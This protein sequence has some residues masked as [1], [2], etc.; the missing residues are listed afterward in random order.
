MRTLKNNKVINSVLQ[1]HTGSTGGTKFWFQTVKL[2][3]LCSF[4]LCSLA[5][6]PDT[7]RG[8]C[9]QVREVDYLPSRFRNSWTYWSDPWDH[10]CKWLDYENSHNKQTMVKKESPHFS[11]AE[12]S[13]CWGEVGNPCEG[14]P[15][16]SSEW[17]NFH[18]WSPPQLS[19]CP[20]IPFSPGWWLE[21][22]RR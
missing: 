10:K 14:A 1:G 19:S 3:G 17:Q 12:P 5:S 7:G 16:F 2:H 13:S 18:R 9:F 22:P 6:L 21:P 20:L 15:H 8:T 11:F 4:P